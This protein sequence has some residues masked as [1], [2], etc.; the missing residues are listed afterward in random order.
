MISCTWGKTKG[1]V[2]D[3]CLGD[4]TDGED[5]KRRFVQNRNFKLDIW[6]RTGSWLDHSS[7]PLY[8]CFP[9]NAPK[10]EEIWFI[11][12]QKQTFQV[13][14]WQTGSHQGFWRGHSPGRMRILVKGALR[15]RVLGVWAGYSALYPVTGHFSF[16][17]AARARQ[18]HPVSVLALCPHPLCCQHDSFVSLGV[19][20]PSLLRISW[21]ACELP[22]IQDW[23]S[24]RVALGWAK[25]VFVF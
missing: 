11:Q 2:Q 12:R 9:R 14:N 24:R 15:H 23:G 6:T 5:G 17:S 21:E 25:V 16:D 8:S 7:F 3:S 18:C 13:Q 20:I 10:W 1:R 22:A 4:R 19:L